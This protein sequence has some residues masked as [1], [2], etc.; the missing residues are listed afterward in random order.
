MNFS[1]Y[2]LVSFGDSFTFGQDTVKRKADTYKPHIDH[3]NNVWWK[4]QCNELSYTKVIADR[5]GFK[6]SLNFGIP[7]GSNDRSLLLLET[8][9]R[10]NPTLKIF[11][12][13][14][15]TSSSRYLSIFKL[16]H[17]PMYDIVEMAPAATYWI[18]P[19]RYTG[20]D[21]KSIANHYTYFRNSVHEMYNHIKERR[22][23][24]YMLSAHNVPHVSFD[25]LNDMDY[26]ILRDNPMQYIHDNDGFGIDDLY[27][28][29]EYNLTKMDYFNSY[30]EELKNDSMMLSHLGVNYVEG[31]RNL[32]D[33]MARLATSQGYTYDHYTDPVG[34]HWTHE[35]HI[36]IAK[37]IEKYINEN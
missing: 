36:E 34:R 11:V 18:E 20:I 3:E 5:M 37:L 31:G 16:D 19:G 14:N 12:L 23:L 30:Y 24:Y 9:L 26:H 8:F 7:A 15:F 29:D 10:T 22:S 33:Y 2:T 1:E 17:E 35:G 32:M 4:A 27:S 21:T 13:F 25:I 6:N 28:N